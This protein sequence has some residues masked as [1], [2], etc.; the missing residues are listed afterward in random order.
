MPGAQ[1]SDAVVLI[2]G[3]MGSELVDVRGEVVWGLRPKLF[4]G[5]LVGRDILGRLRLP[6][7]APDDGITPSRLLAVPG[8]LPM[9]DGVDPYRHLAARLRR[10]TVEPDAVLEF[11]Y[12]WRR[13]IAYNAGRLHSAAT[14]HLATWTDHTRTLPGYVEGQ[15]SPRLALVCHSMG[16]LVARYF[17]EV[18]G[19]RDI[20]R[21]VVTLGTPFAGAMKA[22]RLLAHGDVL[23]LGVLAADV[24]DAARTFPGVYDLLPRFPCVGGGDTLETLSPSMVGALG[25]DCELAEAA[26]EIH[27]RVIDNAAAAGTAV[28]PIRPMVG[29]TQPTLASVRVLAGEA[30]F[31]ERLDS[32]QR[33]GGD[34]TVLRDHAF[35]SDSTASYL[36]QRHGRL[37]STNE[38]IEFVV[39]VLTER[40]LGAYQGNGIGL[41]LPDAARAGVPFE[42]EVDGGRATCRLI[43]ADTGLQVDQKATF[44]REG[45]WLAALT[46]KAPG[47]HRVTASGGGFSAVEDLLLV[48]G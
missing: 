13:S 9:L 10:T 5:R 42:V 14:A 46:A 41:G 31:D 19:G 34:S 45:R 38:A 25:G 32:D 40:R 12:D 8:Y 22:V 37:A 35:A 15:P 28:C 18:L 3:I 4:F 6:P 26:A 33:R 16:G 21:V 39:A 24:R 36:P 27:G 20:T 23:P 44:R 30:V 11:A 48:L 17:T 47:L 1:T 2:P 29:V 7:G 43:D